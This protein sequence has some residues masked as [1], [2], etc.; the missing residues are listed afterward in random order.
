MI[1]A[2]G[3][4]QLAH[5]SEVRALASGERTIDRWH[6]E[7]GDV[8]W[9]DGHYYSV[10][11]PGMAAFSTPLYLL[12]DATGGR[13][14]AADAAAQAAKADQPRWVPN[15]GAP[16]SSFGYDPARTR[17]HFSAGPPCHRTRTATVLGSV[18][19]PTS[20]LGSLEAA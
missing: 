4:A 2:T 6:W 3:W 10:K 11:S 9:I 16:W 17:S 12:I 20:T 13:E 14:L 7:T 19:S 1:H 5:F 15:D 18:P 8:A